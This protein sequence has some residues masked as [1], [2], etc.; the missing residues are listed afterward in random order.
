[1][2]SPGELLREVASTVNMLSIAGRTLLGLDTNPVPA[3]WD[4]ISKVDPEGEKRLPVAFPLYLSETSAVS[5]GGSRDVT[6]ENTEETMELV[7]ATGAPTLH[8]P[9]GPGHVTEQTRENAE[10]LAIPEVLN[11]DTEAIVGTLG[12]GLDY[13]RGELGPDL[14]QERLGLPLNVGG[15]LGGRLGNFAAAY[16][17]RE[18]M[19]EA[20]IIMNPD[21][22]AAREAGVTEADLLSPQA[23]RERAIAAEYHLESEVVYL[24]YSGR[25]GGEEAVEILDELDDALTTPR[26]WYGGGLDS[27]ERAETVLDA[28]ADAVVVGDVLHD[29]ADIEADLVAQA[30]GRFDEVPDHER[31]TDWVE[32]TVDVGETSATRYLS[33]IP[34][35][36]APE[37]TATRYLAAGI[38]FTL[39]VGAVADDLEAPDA[40]QVAETLDGDSRLA[41]T[42]LA[43]TLDGARAELP[44]RIAATLLAER[45]DT[46]TDDGFAAR[47][48][49]VE[50]DD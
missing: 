13:V 3:E 25:F 19:F 11:G 29:I 41:E 34:D 36:A 12:K 31:L 48:L 18:A 42:R 8:E 28:G 7:A 17:M 24:E 30:R 5:V 35:L 32:Q 22:A 6:A 10:M 49:G 50:L 21:S 40:E 39:A 37:E 1:M 43:E 15:L 47:H 38:E 20:Y 33:T 26:L 4:H 44:R 45:F 9:S 16:L 14:V 2:T 46:D 23:A 27:T